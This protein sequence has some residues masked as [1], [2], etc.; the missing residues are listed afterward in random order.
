LGAD[1]RDTAVVFDYSVKWGIKIADKIREAIAVGVGGECCRRGE[2]CAPTDLECI[3]ESVA[4]GV[5][6]TWKRAARGIINMNI[7]VG[8]GFRIGGRQFFGIGFG[9][10]D[11]SIVVIVVVFIIISDDRFT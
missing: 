2:G 5:G 7:A 10:V 4:V 3:G 9:N 11:E 6:C 8:P 1:A